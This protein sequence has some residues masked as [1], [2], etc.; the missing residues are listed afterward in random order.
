VSG[1]K[2]KNHSKFLV[3]YHIIFVVKY[4]KNLL[5]QYGDTI[6]QIILT[7]AKQSSFDVSEMETDKDHRY[8]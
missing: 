3:I 2:T 1:Y 4:R 5:D 8:I 6:K 7:V